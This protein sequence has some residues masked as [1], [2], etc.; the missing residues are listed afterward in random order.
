MTK[1]KSPRKLLSA[2]LVLFFAVPAFAQSDKP[3]PV[4]AT[5]SILGDMV[6]RIGGPQIEL[7]HARRSQRR[8]AC[9]STHTRRCPWGQ[10]SQASF[11]ERA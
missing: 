10:Q 8:H 4:V 7:Y 5:F 9:L 3:I 2:I 11:R 1:R 6:K